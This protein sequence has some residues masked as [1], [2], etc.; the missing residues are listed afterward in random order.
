MCSNIVQYYRLAI[1]RLIENVNVIKYVPQKMSKMSKFSLNKCV[2]SI[3]ITKARFR[4][5]LHPGP[6]WGAYDARTTHCL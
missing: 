3:L 4:P 1:D 6:D 5:G 2:L